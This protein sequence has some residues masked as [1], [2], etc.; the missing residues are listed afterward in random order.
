MKLAVFVSGK[1]TNLL[2]IIKK[3]EEGF[4]KSEVRLVISNRDCE[5]VES[6]TRAGIQ[7]KVADPKSFAS[8]VE[9]GNSI[10]DALKKSEVDFVV[11]AGFL[12]KVPDVVVKNF[13]NR[14]INIHPALL[15]SFGGK[16]MYGMKVHQAVIDSGCKVS[17]A[18]VHIVDAEYDHGPIVLQRCVPVS[19]DDTPESLASKIHQLEYELLPEAIKLFEENRVK[20][21]GRKARFFLS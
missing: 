14:V 4:L 11:L 20:V 9:F 10:L 2:N 6:S 7:T 16:G 13:E 21:E 15:P 1:G 5:A 18:T 8:E 17:G 19:G 12:K 3:H